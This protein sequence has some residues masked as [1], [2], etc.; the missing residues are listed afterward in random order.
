MSFNSTEDDLEDLFGKYG[1]VKSALVV[2]DRITGRPRG[3]GFVHFYTR[4]DADKALHAAYEG[5]SS[6]V[7][8]L[9]ADELPAGHAISRMEGNL[10]LDGRRLIISRAI[11][12]DVASKLST[13]ET[14]K[15]DKRNL[16]LV[17]LSAIPE[18]SELEELFTTQELD[19]RRKDVAAR[20]KKLKSNTNLFVSPTRISL[21]N[22]PLHI[23]EKELKAY[24]LDTVI[25][26]TPSMCKIPRHKITK[27]IVLQAKMLRDPTRIEKDGLGRSKGFGF[28]EFK[29]HDDAKT[30]LVHSN[31][32]KFPLKEA[33]DK[34]FQEGPVRRMITEFA[35]E[36]VR[37]V[38]KHEQKLK[39]QNDMR[40]RKLADAEAEKEKE[41]EEK[42]A[43]PPSK[44]AKLSNKK[45]AKVEPVV[46]KEMEPEVAEVVTPKVK[47]PRS[48]R[49]KLKKQGGN[50]APQEKLL[51]KPVI[52]KQQ[53]DGQVSGKKKRNA[54]KPSGSTSFDQEWEKIV[55]ETEKELA[56]SAPS[57][58]SRK[59]SSKMTEEE[60]E[61]HLESLVK[62]YR[63]TLFG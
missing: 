31:T 10:V 51:P 35:V 40:K 4:A 60:E 37:A 24:V 27:K 34:S 38:K 32:K 2:E 57:E 63:N 61:K 30:F 5:L 23:T 46:A 9:V 20:M 28:V 50:A 12:R 52:Q 41:K 45:A 8:A 49:R 1:K 6:D 11:D 47:L 43:G 39:K 53:Q 54:G 7:S 62:E 17:Q 26:N 59:K 36:N 14:A 44:K 25:R 56:S 16:H 18:G 55:A 33:A 29:D 3:T 22:L 48:Q 21:R 15:K 42:E 19:F 13:T 58:K